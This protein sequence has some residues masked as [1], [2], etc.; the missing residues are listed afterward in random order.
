MVVFGLIWA[1]ALGLGTTGGL[2]IVVIG[3]S[4]AVMSHHIANVT[5]DVLPMVVVVVVWL[6]RTAIIINT[7]LWPLRRVLILTWPVL[8]AVDVGVIII[9]IA[10]TV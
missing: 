5:I 6:G 9:V 2:I 1:T 4:A 7:V 3:A 8:V 10:A